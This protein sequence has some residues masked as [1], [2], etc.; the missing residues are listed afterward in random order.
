MD[1]KVQRSAAKPDR[2]SS[3]LETYMVAENRVSSDLHVY[4][5]MFVCTNN[6]PIK[7]KAGFIYIAHETY[8]SAKVTSLVRGPSR[9]QT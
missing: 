1:Q 8:I 6:T 5:H 4:T 9:S 3:I 7:M 2:L